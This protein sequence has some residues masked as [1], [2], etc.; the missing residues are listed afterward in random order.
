MVVVTQGV[1]DPAAVGEA[2]VIRFL[3]LIL[4]IN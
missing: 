2:M 4:I 3:K 1:E